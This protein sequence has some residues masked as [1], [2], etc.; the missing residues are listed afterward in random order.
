LEVAAVQGA[1]PDGRRGTIKKLARRDA[2]IVEIFEAG[3]EVK[4]DLRNPAGESV[5]ARPE[6]M[7]DSPPI[8]V[9]RRPLPDRP[10]TPVILA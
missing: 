8:A 9:G 10:Q 2:L 1:D 7:G 6:A 3:S 4:I 5:R